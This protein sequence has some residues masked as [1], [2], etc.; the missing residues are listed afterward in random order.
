MGGEAVG[1]NRRN[2]KNTQKDFRTCH[3]ENIFALLL[4]VT[5][6]HQFE[7]FV[8]KIFWGKSR[9]SYSMT[10]CDWEDSCG[11]I[12]EK[13]S[14]TLTLEASK[15]KTGRKHGKLFGESL[16]LV[17]PHSRKQKKRTPKHYPQFPQVKCVR[18]TLYSVM[19]GKGLKNTSS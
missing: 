9:S 1:M 19:G 12:T 6:L 2:I 18:S 16:R 10:W 14:G 11:I 17:T 13:W 3:H 4:P 5:K 7:N 8:L 15:I